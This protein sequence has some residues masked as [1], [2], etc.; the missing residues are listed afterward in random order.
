MGPQTLKEQKRCHWCSVAKVFREGKQF[1]ETFE[2]STLEHVRRENNARADVLSKLASAKRLGQC[3]IVIQETLY[4]A[5]I[6]VEETLAVGDMNEDWMEPMRK[7]LKEDILP[8]DP[9]AAHKIRRQ[10]AHYTMAEGVSYRWGFSTP[11]LKCLN[12]QQA[13]YATTE[14]HEG[15]CGLH[16]GGQ[17]LATKLL[18]VGYFW[19]TLRSD[20]IKW[21][22]KCE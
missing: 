15:I 4:S 20:C 22:Q 6:D 11:L 7:F 16:D 2:E 13:E 5:S 3:K 10:A 19:P 21:I 12:P 9:K 17:P 1:R 18:R 14:V 8:E